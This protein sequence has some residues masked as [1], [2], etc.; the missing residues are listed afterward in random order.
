[1]TGIFNAIIEKVDDWYIGY[2]EELPGVNTQ[3]ETLEEI[4]E[5]LREA[6]LLILKSNRELVKKQIKGKK[7]IREKIDF[8]L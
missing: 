3:G 6:I 5:N 7:V 4:R 2:V 8:A 1:M